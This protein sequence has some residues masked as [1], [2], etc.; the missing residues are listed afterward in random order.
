MTLS[1]KNREEKKKDKLSDKC[2]L[3]AH[4]SGTQVRKDAAERLPA[5]KDSKCP[6]CD[7]IETA[8]PQYHGFPPTSKQTH[9]SSP[10]FPTSPQK[11]KKKGEKV[12]A[13]DNVQGW[14]DAAVNT[15]V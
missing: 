10:P 6:A 11:K 3:G 4:T 8:I 1:K 7:H 5:Y 13:A 15:R 9:N 14:G 2:A 12:E